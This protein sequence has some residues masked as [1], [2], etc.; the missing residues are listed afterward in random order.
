MG[1]TGLIAATELEI[2]SKPRRNKNASRRGGR[3]F[4]APSDTEVDPDWNVGRLEPETPE[5][6]SAN[7]YG[8]ALNRAVGDFMKLPEIQALPRGEEKKAIIETFIENLN[9]NYPF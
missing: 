6:A 3:A 8:I 5:Q 9:A 7:R 4:P 2:S 1:G